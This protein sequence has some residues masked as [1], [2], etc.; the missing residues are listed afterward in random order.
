MPIAPAPIPAI[1]ILPD[2]ATTL[3]ITIKEIS[4]DV[5]HV[6]FASLEH[7]EAFRLWISNRLG[8]TQTD[9]NVPGFG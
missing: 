4:E 3:R 9:E 7:R 6:G 8:A 1:L 5:L 2:P